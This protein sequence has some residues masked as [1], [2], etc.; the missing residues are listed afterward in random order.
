MFMIN[1]GFNIN[2]NQTPVIVLHQVKTVYADFD[3]KLK[4]FLKRHRDLSKETYEMLVKY[5]VVLC[6]TPS[7]I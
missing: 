5:D 4:I 1:L 2:V 7:L 3:Y 6:R